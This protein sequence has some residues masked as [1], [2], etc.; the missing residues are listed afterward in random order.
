[1]I[2]VSVPILLDPIFKFFIEPPT[3]GNYLVLGTDYDSYAVVWSCT[4]SLLSN[5]RK[6]FVYISRIDEKYEWNRSLH[7]ELLWILTRDRE[8]SEAVI[9]SAMAVIESNNLNTSKL[10]ITNQSNCPN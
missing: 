2:S 10:R 7:T 3:E 8:P 5:F 6:F 1:M 4:P 9:N